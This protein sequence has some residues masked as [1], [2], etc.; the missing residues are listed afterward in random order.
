MKIN[1]LASRFEFN[2]SYNPDYKE[3]GKPGDV[4][5]EKPIVLITGVDYLDEDLNVV[6]RS[7]FSQPIAKRD[8]DEILL[9]SRID[10]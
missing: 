5:S 7:N 1:S 4:N 8:F 3:I 6:M 10:F 9:R 2:K